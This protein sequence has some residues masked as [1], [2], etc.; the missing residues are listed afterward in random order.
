ME[1]H[2]LF[3]GF[4]IILPFQWVFIGIQGWTDPQL[5]LLPLRGVQHGPP[6]SQGLARGS[7]YVAEPGLRQGDHRGHMLQAPHVNSYA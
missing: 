5:H 6:S 4:F 3:V 2:R 7:L 1:N